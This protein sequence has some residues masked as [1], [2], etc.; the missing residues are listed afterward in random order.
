[1]LTLVDEWTRE[2]LAIDVERRLNS[3]SVLD[4]LADL[5]VQRGTPAYL[6]S[7][8]YETLVKFFRLGLRI[9]LGVQSS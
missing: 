8:C 2:C 5:F 3:Q 6:R 4:R 9:P 7:A 1:M